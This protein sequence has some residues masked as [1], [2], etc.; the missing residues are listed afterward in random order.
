ML[1]STSSK[2]NRRGEGRTKNKGAI[3]VLFEVN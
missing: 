2:E 3:Q 1:L